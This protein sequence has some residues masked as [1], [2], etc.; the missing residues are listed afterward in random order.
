M[1][2]IN[3]PLLNF[4][5]ERDIAGGVLVYSGGRWLIEQ[6]VLSITV[7]NDRFKQVKDLL[8]GP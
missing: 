2:Q 6:Y 3:E 4:N 8:S 7:P 1:I 5:S